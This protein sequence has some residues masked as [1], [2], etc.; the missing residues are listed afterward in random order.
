[1][2]NQV[3]RIYI[4]PDAETGTP[5]YRVRIGPL[6]SVDAADLAAQRLESMGLND[7]Q[8]IVE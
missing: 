5:L 6:S 2:L 3:G 4:H 1:V 7:F 8:V